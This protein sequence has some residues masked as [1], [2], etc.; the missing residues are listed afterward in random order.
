MKLK[1]VVNKTHRR[2]KCSFAK[3]L[4]QWYQVVDDRPCESRIYRKSHYTFFLRI[5][6]SFDNID[7]SAKKPRRRRRRVKPQS[8]SREEELLRLQNGMKGGRVGP[9]QSIL[10][11]KQ[12]ET[13]RRRRKKA[14]RRTTRAKRVD[15]EEEREE[16]RKNIF[17]LRRQQIFLL[18]CLDFFFRQNDERSSCSLSLACFFSPLHYTHISSPSSR[19]RFSVVSVE[20]LARYY[21]IHT[22]NICMATVEKKRF[23]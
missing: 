13:R 12:R 5:F 3:K 20:T 8:S 16:G 1:R 2:K 21:H 17:N 15:D 14:Q 11:A 9:I 6:T 19:C 10:C 22:H 23:F 7:T 18:K 4:R